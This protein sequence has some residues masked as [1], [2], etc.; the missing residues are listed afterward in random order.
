[1][2]CVVVGLGVS[3]VGSESLPSIYRNWSFHNLCY[4]NQSE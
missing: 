2:S 4:A 3:S 1:M